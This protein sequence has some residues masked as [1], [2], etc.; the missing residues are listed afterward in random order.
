MVSV[1]PVLA[2]FDDGGRRLMLSDAVLPTPSKDSLT[3]PRIF[4]PEFYRKF[5]PEL[6]LSTDADAIK[7]WTSSGANHCLRGAFYFSAADYLKRYKGV[8]SPSAIPGA[9]D[10]AIR[11]F[12]TY[13]FNRGRIGAF[14][15]YPIVFD[16]NYYVDAANNPDLNVLFGNGTWDQEDIQIHW[17]QRGIEERRNASAFFSIRDYQ[18]RYRDASQLTPDKALYQ[19]VTAGQAARRLGKQEWADLSEWSELVAKS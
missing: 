4:D 9:C 10:D 7:Q 13:G 14:D 15:S 18:S 19:Y 16:F 5:N 11:D 2:Q 8:D 17:L 3:D 1:A 12:V 6:G